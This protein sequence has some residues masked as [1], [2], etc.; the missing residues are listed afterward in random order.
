MYCIIPVPPQ[1]KQDIWVF[2]CISEV[3]KTHYHVRT[4]LEIVSSEIDTDASMSN[5]P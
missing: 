5:Y 3:L 1:Y 4:L 2:L